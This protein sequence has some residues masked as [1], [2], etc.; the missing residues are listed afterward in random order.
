MAYKTAVAET[1]ASID[2]HDPP[3]PTKC[4]ATDN[5]SQEHTRTETRVVDR[6]PCQ[7]NQPVPFAHASIKPVVMPCLSMLRIH[8]PDKD[9]VHD[10]ITPPLHHESLLQLSAPCTST[11]ISASATVFM[12]PLLLSVSSVSIA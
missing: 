12:S 10:T 7:R 4:L 9:N 3:V 5:I 2:G 1:G 11:S 6:D 8:L